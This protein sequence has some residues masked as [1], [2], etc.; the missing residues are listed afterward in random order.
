MTTADPPKRKR[1][2]LYCILPVIMHSG[3][4][5]LVT[6]ILTQA[7]RYIFLLF[8]NLNPR[9]VYFHQND[10]IFYILVADLCS[11]AVFTPMFFLKER[12]RFD[13]RYV[14]SLTGVR[15][16]QLA[17]LGAGMHSVVNVLVNIVNTIASN[18][19]PSTY[20][21]F[22][23][24]MGILTTGALFQFMVVAV[25]APMAEE[26][27][28]R[29][30]VFNRF[31]TYW[32]PKWAVFLSAFLF[33]LMH[34]PSMVQVSYAFFL[35][36][37]IAIAYQKHQRIAAAFVIHMSFNATNFIYQ[38]RPLGEFVQGI[39]TSAFNF[40]VYAIVSFARFGA[41]IWWLLRT[42]PA[43]LK[44]EYQASPP[45]GTTLVSFNGLEGINE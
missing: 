7:P 20:I 43:Q 41:G 27:A 31:R 28:L 39:N 45:G 18:L 8:P 22:N 34:L 21:S 6:T 33:G 19:F 30:L 11:L 10:M 2:A 26:M 12:K 3:I 23:T 36:V 4:T 29:G 40:I 42:K 35:G 17:V 38:F 15:V 13:A 25:A 1:R 14:N 32:S 44:S 16:L 5:F 9:I 37:V 24:M